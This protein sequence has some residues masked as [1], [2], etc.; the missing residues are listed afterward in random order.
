MQIQEYNNAMQYLISLRHTSTDI[1]Q[2]YFI[3]IIDSIIE[4]VCCYPTERI[5]SEV[6]DFV[7][8]IKNNKN[9]FLIN[10]L[11][12]MNSVE[13]DNHTQKVNELRKFMT[14]YHIDENR[15]SWK[16]TMTLMQYIKNDTVNKSAIT[17]DGSELCSDK[18]LPSSEILRRHKIFFI[19]TESLE[20]TPDEFSLFIQSKI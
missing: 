7:N 16:N 17:C 18:P 8:H 13:L 19:R 11:N 14:R 4:E 1:I 15:S 6:I 2:L 3:K 9:T 20:Y 5:M 12:Y 10:K